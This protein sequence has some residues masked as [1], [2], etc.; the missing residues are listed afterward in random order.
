[1]PRARDALSEC[2]DH[3]SPD[4]LRSHLLFAKLSVVLGDYG[5]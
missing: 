2:Y 5:R 1:V 4:V 3:E